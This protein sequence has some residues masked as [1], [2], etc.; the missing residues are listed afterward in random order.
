MGGSSVTGG[1]LARVAMPVVLAG[2]DPFRRA[3]AGRASGVGEATAVDAQA[4]R[5]PAYGALAD[6][7][8]LVHEFDGDPAG[9]PLVVPP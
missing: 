3:P 9:E 5:P 2:H 6:P 7:H 8:P 4:R 1:L